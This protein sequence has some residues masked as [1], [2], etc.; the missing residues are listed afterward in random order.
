M[1]LKLHALFAR[2]MD[3]ADDG[4]GG[5]AGGGDAAAIA[6]GDI[7]VNPSTQEEGVEPVSATAEELAAEELA[8]PRDPETGKF[9][10]KE[11]DTDSGPMIPKTRFDEQ[12]GKERAGREAAERRAAELEA[13]IGKVQRNLDVEKAVADVAALRKAE[14]AALLDGNEDKAAELSS[15][16]DN[17]NRQIAIAESGHLTGQ[18]KDQA[19]E[20]IRMEMTVERMEEKYP[21]LVAG[22]EDYDQELVD[23]I[24]DKQDGLIRRERLSPSKALARAVEYIMDRT[25][26]AASDEK[27]GLGAA[28]TSEDRKA[29]AV[30]KNLDAAARQPGKTSAAGLDSD[31]AG[32]TTD[33][34]NAKDMSAEAYNALP[35]ETRARMRGDII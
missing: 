21:Q 20:D 11:K 3:A 13:S 17:L 2:L 30:A 31:K 26:P 29:A 10:K 35:E 34:P 14:R 7:I 23:D 15:Q 28:K 33:V 4:T 19:L 27:V 18:A 1:N 16:A 8:K 12:L 5:S 6:R 9:A 22:S 25:K 24:L 32:K